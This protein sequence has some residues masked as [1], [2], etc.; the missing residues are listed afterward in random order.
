MIFEMD[1]SQVKQLGVNFRKLAGSCVQDV[2]AIMKKGA[3]NVKDEM[4]ADARGSRHFHPLARAITYERVPRVREI[5]FVIGP[6]K[7][8]FGGPLGNIYYF[9]TSRGGGSGDIEKPLRSEAPRMESALT[10]MVD[11]FGRRL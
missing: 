3:Q 11:Q 2:E 9:G 6:D 7:D 1:T 8:R 4:I 5:R 10:R